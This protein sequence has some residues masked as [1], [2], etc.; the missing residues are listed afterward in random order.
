MMSLAKTELEAEAFA[1]ANLQTAS[2][3][4]AGLYQKLEATLKDDDEEDDETISIEEKK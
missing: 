1:E 4:L 3:N 2:K